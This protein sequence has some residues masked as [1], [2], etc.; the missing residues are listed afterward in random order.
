VK[1]AVSVI[2]VTGSS[3]SGELPKEVTHH[4]IRAK[5]FKAYKV[6]E[7]QHIPEIERFIDDNF[8]TGGKNGGIRMGF[9]PQS[10]PFVRGIFTTAV[11]YNPDVTEESIRSSFAAL[12]GKERFVRIVTGSPEVSMVYGTNFVE[13]AWAHRRGFIVSMSAIDNLVKGA[14]GQAVQN[15]NIMFGFPEDEGIRFPGMIP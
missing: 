13:V 7:H 3:G 5:N 10:G 4:P 2:A 6:L 15:M 12:Y 1:D 8:K 11:V 9:V 14:S